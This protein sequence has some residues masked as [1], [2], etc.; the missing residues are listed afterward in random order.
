[1]EAIVNS[2]RDNK[3]L[4]F[5]YVVHFSDEQKLD[6]GN[7]MYGTNSQVVFIIHILYILR[8]IN[9][10]APHNKV[11]V[12]NGM[13]IKRDK[14]TCHMVKKDILL[15][16]CVTLLLPCIISVGILLLLCT[17]SIGILLFL[18]NL[19]LPLFFLTSLP[20]IAFIHYKLN[21]DST[22]WKIF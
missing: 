4:I 10:N 15:C 21:S 7:R 9:V 18:C 19:G 16:C 1:M 22:L 20:Y 2:I 12:C 17:F 6:L 11:P 13:N 5:E 8:L 3:K 14:C